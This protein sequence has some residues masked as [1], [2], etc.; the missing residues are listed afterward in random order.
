[1]K[2]SQ[3][4]NSAQ[5][6]LNEDILFFKETCASTVIHAFLIAIFRID[7]P[8]AARVT[9]VTYMWLAMSTVDR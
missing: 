4:V 3:E 1:E 7:G 9:K 5:E 2:K 8:F 6:N